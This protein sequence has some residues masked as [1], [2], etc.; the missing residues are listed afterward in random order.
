M[1]MMMLLLTRTLVKLM[2]EMMQLMLGMT[3]TPAQM[4]TMGLTSEPAREAEA[5]VAAAAAE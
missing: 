5:A 1:M 2:P 3:R 4:I